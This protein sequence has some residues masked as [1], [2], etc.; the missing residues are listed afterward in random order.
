MWSKHDEVRRL[1]KTASDPAQRTPEL[2]KSLLDEVEGMIFK[3]ENILFPAS[4]ERID[5]AEWVEIFKA[6]EQ[7][8]FPFLR[9]A[10]LHS[11]LAEAESRGDTSRP[12][13]E[14]EISMP[15]GRLSVEELTAMLDALPVDITFVDAADN[16]KYFS[17]SRDRIFVR[18]TSVLGRSV[19]NCHP[20]QSLAKVTEIL[21]AFRAGTRDHADFWIPLNGKFVYIRYFAVRDPNRRYLGTLEVTQDLTEIRTLSGERRLLG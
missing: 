19:Q 4:L 17:Q 14:G 10:G 8:G 3:E 12:E 20:P 11:T 18:A 16:V 1:L 7:I 5:P 2:L 15:S 13:A 21:E 9:G 6:C